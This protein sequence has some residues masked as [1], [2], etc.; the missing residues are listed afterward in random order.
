MHPRRSALHL[1][2]IVTVLMATTGCNGSRCKTPARSDGGLGQEVC[3]PAGSFVM[4]HA[5]LP[6][7]SP[8]AGGGCTAEP[9]N[10]WAPAHEVYL[11]SFYIDAYEVTWGRYRSCVAQG[12][13]STEAISSQPTGLASLN[14]PDM[15]QRPAEHLRW[16]DA[17]TFCLW[18]GKRL[19]TEA[20]WER[21]ARGPSD[22]DYPWGELQPPSPGE[23][24][25]A[26]ESAEG[27]HGLFGNV[28]EWVDD[29]YDPGYYANAPPQSPPGPASSVRSFT[30]NPAGGCFPWIIAHDERVVRGLSFQPLQGDAWYGKA[31]AWFRSHDRPGA[32]GYRVRC[33]RDDR[34]AGE[35][36]AGGQWT[37]RGLT[38]NPI[39][40]MNRGGH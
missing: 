9:Q 34:A 31:P 1:A 18:E 25:T 7:V 21:A 37:F 6:P 14:S 17:L 36:P 12:F 15:A 38:W 39:P 10:D 16:A 40:R 27:V 5:P 35:R 3:I 30:H 4:G 11:D 32:Q 28:G 2:A 8:P 23:A 26:G 19:P 33:A 22:L 29:W 20:E 13:C 24:P